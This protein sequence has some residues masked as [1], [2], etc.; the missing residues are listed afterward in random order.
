MKRFLDGPFAFVLGSTAV[1][2][3]P[4]CKVDATMRGRDAS[5]NRNCMREAD[6]LYL[7]CISDI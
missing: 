3:L 4:Q 2:R 6:R 5:R 7:E 1:V